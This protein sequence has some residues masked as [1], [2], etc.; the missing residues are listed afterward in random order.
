[1]KLRMLVTLDGTHDGQPWPPVGGTLEIDHPGA[2]ADLVRNGLAE[3]IEL[4]AVETTQA[5][6]PEHAAKRVGKTAPR[7]QVK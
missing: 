7:K 6:A 4:R 5:V 2:A 1:M 3:L